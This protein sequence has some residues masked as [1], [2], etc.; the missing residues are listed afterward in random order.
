MASLTRGVGVSFWEEGGLKSTKGFT[1]LQFELFKVLGVSFCTHSTYSNDIFKLP[2][3]SPM[4]A[5][6]PI[7]IA[8]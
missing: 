4:I 6:L 8:T 2:S 7:L 5:V 1:N 3:L